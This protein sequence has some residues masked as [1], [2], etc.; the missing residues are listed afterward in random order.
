MTSWTCPVSVVFMGWKGMFS[1]RTLDAGPVAYRSSAML[2][3]AVACA[4]RVQTAQLGSWQKSSIYSPLTG[5]LATA[6]R[7]TVEPYLSLNHC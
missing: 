5:V 2:V 1:G 4:R 3:G 7:L 6:T